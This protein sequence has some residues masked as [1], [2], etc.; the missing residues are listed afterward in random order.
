MTAKAEE[1]SAQGLY[2]SLLLAL[3]LATAPVLQKGLALCPA[4]LTALAPTAPRAPG[5]TASLTVLTLLLL[6]WPVS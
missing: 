4:L 3:A 6:A 2:L 1:R 5:L